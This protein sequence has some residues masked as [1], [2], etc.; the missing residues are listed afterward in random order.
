MGH[1]I[2]RTIA[3]VM[4]QTERSFEIVVVDDGSADDGAARAEALAAKQTDRRITVVRQPNAGVSVARNTGI[5]HSCGEFVAFMDADDEFTPDHLATLQHLIDT[6]PQYNVY[7]TTQKVLHNGTERLQSFKNLRFKDVKEEN[8]AATEGVMESYFLTASSRHNPIHVGSLVVRRKALDTV[9]F[10]VGIVS[11]Q[12]L[13][14]MA[15]LMTENEVVL[16]LHQTYLYNFE[17]RGRKYGL[18]ED[19]DK[20]FDRL[21]TVGCRDKH[22]RSYVALWHTRRAIGGMAVGRYDIFAYHL[23]RSLYIKPLQTKA[24]TAI[25]ANARHCRL[26]RKKA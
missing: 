3:S 5:D 13:S 2:E 9:R 12:D 10:P 4:Q 25:I 21:L 24:F 16:S 18:H 20:C 19:V 8:G 1:T 15:H 11:G 6:F 7:A 14:F 23:W 26:R 22:L 17:E